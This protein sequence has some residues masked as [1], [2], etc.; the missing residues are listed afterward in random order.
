MSVTKENIIKYAENGLKDSKSNNYDV[1]EYYAGK[2]QGFR[3]II[4]KAEHLNLKELITEIERMETEGNYWHTQ[5]ISKKGKQYTDGIGIA[6]LETIEG[7]HIK[8][9]KRKK[10][11]A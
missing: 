3:R 2:R 10:L 5:N 6:A 1:K 8:S 9:L 4:E 7:L 11:L